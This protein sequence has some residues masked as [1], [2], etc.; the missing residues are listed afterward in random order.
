MEQPAD[1]VDEDRPEDDGLIFGRTSEYWSGYWHKELTAEGKRNRQWRRLAEDIC[2]R[3]VDERQNQGASPNYA[4]GTAEFRLNLFY[5]NTFTLE[6]FLYGRLP[7][8]DMSRRFADPNDDAARVAANILERMMNTSIETDGGDFSSVLRA[9]LQDHLVPGLAQSWV[10]YEMATT[11]VQVPPEVDPET[12]LELV[13][14]YEREELLYE[15]APVDYVPWRDFRWGYGRIWKDVPWVGKDVHLKKREAE[16]RFG[17]EIAEQLTYESSSLDIEDKSQQNPDQ[18]DPAKTTC[19]TEI[20]CKDVE[21]VF[22]YEAKGKILCDAKP[23]PLDL[24]GFFPCP[25][26]MMANVTTTL[27]IPRPYFILGQDLYNEIDQLSTRINIITNAVK[28]VGVYDKSV[29]ELK[30]M[31]QNSIENDMV[32]VDSWAMLAEKGGLKG[33]LEFFPVEDVVTVLVQLRQMRAE[34]IDLLYQVTGLAD[35]MR[36][37]GEKYEG[38][39][40]A[41]L[42][43]KFG[44]VRVQYLQEEF[45]RFASDTLTLKAQ[46]ISRHFDPQTIVQ[47]SNIA[48][49]Y[50]AGQIDQAMM[51]IKSPDLPWRCQVKPE[52]MAMIDWAQLKAD[53]TEFINALALFMQSAAPLVEF[54]PGSMPVLLE[55]LKWGLAGFKGSEEIESVLD[56]AIKQ[57]LENPP[58]QQGDDAGNAEVAKSR[59]KMAENQQKFQQDMM[60]QADKARKELEKLVTEFRLKMAEI[61]AG[62]EAD[63]YG[64]VVQADQAIREE[65]AKAKLKPVG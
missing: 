50:D 24:P 8:V 35:I 39:G 46:I 15:D 11:T 31:L 53:R 2:K 61:Q 42:K 38:V 34:T 26:P 28:V 37:G 10:R 14:G 1:R 17:K 65:R 9:S 40:K 27:Q 6:S 25:R 22:W 4:A 49:S 52:S 30:N 18:Q 47:Q 64:E 19:V 13:P 21:G 56:Q 54:M 36:G 58:Q 12:G 59:A 20:W 57:L 33:V 41:Q 44:S 7:R 45:A 43:A 48:R 60:K 62:A 23:D 5:S 3:Y 55:L 63:A 32:A 51:L 16:E 29:P